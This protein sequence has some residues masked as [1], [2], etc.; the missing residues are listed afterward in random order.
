MRFAYQIDLIYTIGLA[1]L[2][3]IFYNVSHKGFFG[4]YLV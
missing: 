1:E 2:T 4:A 3:W